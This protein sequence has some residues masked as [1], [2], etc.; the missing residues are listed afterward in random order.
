MVLSE[1]H[2]KNKLNIV[3]LETENL[4][5]MHCNIYMETAMIKR[6]NLLPF[7]PSRCIV[8]SF[9]I[10][11]NIPNFPTTRG[12][13]TKISMKMVYQYIAIFY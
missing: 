3:K 2:S 12:F 7:Q 1:N 4:L 9:Y 13:R 10:P 5:M 11:E 6:L 8:A